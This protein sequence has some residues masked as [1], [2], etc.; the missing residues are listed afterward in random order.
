V[1]AWDRYAYV[2]NNPVR[3]NDPSGY[4]VETALDIA[5]IAYDIYDIKTN[6]LTWVSGLSLAADV[7]GALLPVVTGAG[8]AVRAVSHADD[9]VDAAKAADVIIDA[10]ETANKV[11]DIMDAVTHGDD[12]ANVLSSANDVLGLKRP[13]LP[14]WPSTPKEMDEILGM[15]GKRIPDGLDTP[16]RNKVIW[17]PSDYIKITFEQHPYHSGAPAFHKG[18]H[19]H[20]EWPGLKKHLTYLPGQAMPK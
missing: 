20:I 18:L 11:D 8:L 10:V 7:A 9:I 17:N 15:V 1:L 13:N 16:G 12:L 19:W 2:N 4:W 6:G 3:Y 5:F 14:N